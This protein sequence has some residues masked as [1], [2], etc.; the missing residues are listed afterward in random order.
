RVLQD[1][2]ERR[3]GIFI[4]NRIDGLTPEQAG[5]RFG[6]SRT[7]AMRHIANATAAIAEA[8]DLDAAKRGDA[9]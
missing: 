6:V 5:A 7:A 3:R 9:S 4:A 2:S 1:M 8:I